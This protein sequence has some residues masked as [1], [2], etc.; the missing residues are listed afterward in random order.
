MLWV[1]CFRLRKESHEAQKE[2]GEGESIRLCAVPYAATNAT[3]Q[4]Q[5]QRGKA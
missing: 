1:L 4:E 5:T 3:P 2:E